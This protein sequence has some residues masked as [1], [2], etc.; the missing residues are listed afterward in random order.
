MKAIIANYEETFVRA[1]A[2]VAALNIPSVKLTVSWKNHILCVHL[3]PFLEKVQCG[4]SKYSEQVGESAHASM[5]KT[6]VRFSVDECH[7]NHGERMKR[8]IVE[9]SSE[10]V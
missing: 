6:M 1:Q 10:C 2:E 3:P 7:E 4:M 5:K 8:G 9:W